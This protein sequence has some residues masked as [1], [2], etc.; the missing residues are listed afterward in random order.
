MLGLEPK[1][2]QVKLL[3]MAIFFCFNSGP[4]LR[5]ERLVTG[6]SPCGRLLGGSMVI[7]RPEPGL[8]A[9]FYVEPRPRADVFILRCF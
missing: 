9:S 3:K 1:K 5:F 4:S 6:Y 2:E 7:L 8:S